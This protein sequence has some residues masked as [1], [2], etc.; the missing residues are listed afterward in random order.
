MKKWTAETLKGAFP[1]IKIERCQKCGVPIG[2]LEICHACGYKQKK[3]E[4]K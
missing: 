3:E 4:I 2:T 1:N